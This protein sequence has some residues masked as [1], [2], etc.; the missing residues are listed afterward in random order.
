MTILNQFVCSLLLLYLLL[1]VSSSAKSRYDGYLLYKIHIESDWQMQVLRAMEQ[2]NRLY[3]FWKLPTAV[4]RDAELMIPPQKQNDLNKILKRYNFKAEIITNNLQLL[5]D[6]EGMNHNSAATFDWTRYYS[7]NKVNQFLNK[8]H[9]KYKNVT[10]IFEL[11]RTYEGRP[12]FGIKISFKPGN[13]GIFIEANI[14]AREW[15]STATSTWII[16]ELL[17]SNENVIKD[18]AQNVDWYIIP[19][20]NPDGFEYTYTHD[21]IWR[22][23][24][25]P[26]SKSCYGADPNRNFGYQWN[27]G[28]GSDDPCSEIYGGSGPFSEPE[29]LALAHFYAKIANNITA[30]LSFH[31]YSQILMYPYSS[32]KAGRISNEN[33]HK[34]VGKSMVDAL[35]KRYHTTYEF[36]NVVDLLYTASGGSIDWIKVAHNTP[37]VFVYE[38]RDQGKY[39]FMLPAEQIIPT[40]KETLDSIIA[41]V[42]EA[43]K[44]GY[45]K[46]ILNK[47]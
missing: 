24:R 41:M 26:S 39:G 16:N 34:K 43:R 3:I 31:S 7:L 12:I 9:R 44:L 2:N 11:G 46:K 1:I 33:E 25:K 42:K 45:F 23:T 21:R 19:V 13:P 29:V 10:E 35:Y 22:K 37:F 8:I 4:G 30:Y 18:I 20:A 47:T 6:N 36:G 5:M 32:D 15:I 38:L 17:T 40:S 27:T 14:H 28:G